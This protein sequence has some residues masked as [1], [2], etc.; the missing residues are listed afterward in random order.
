MWMD[1]LGLLDGVAA[2]LAVF[3]PAV[4]EAPVEELAA[5]LAPASTGGFG[6][7]RARISD[8]GYR[9]A[10]KTALS[11]WRAGKP[12]PA[13]LHA[14]VAAAAGQAAAPRKGAGGGGPP[15]LL[16]DTQTLYK[17]PE[18]ARLRTA[19]GG[20]GLGPLIEEINH[21]HLSTDLALASAEH[22]WLS[23]VLD[24]VSVAD[25]RVGAFDGQAHLRTVAQFGVADR[26][27]I[28]TTAVRVRRA[29]AENATR[30]RGPPPGKTGVYRPPAP[31]Q[32][33]PPAGPPAVPG[34]A[35]CPRRAP[36]MLG[37]VAAAGLPAAAGRA[38]LRRRH[39]RR[40]V[41]GHPGGRGRSAD[42]R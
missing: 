37:D 35:P 4:F 29:V 22:V 33:R 30:P 15:P 7:L 20:A 14:A 13:A 36:A 5:A 25:P 38:M 11:L 31:P 9:R 17:L 34:R 32:A 42:A 26:A 39:L 10:R 19:L 6:R 18:L 2:S 41:P 16:A 40:G 28:D 1:A 24:T 21:R 3:D 8:G 12:K 27:H 23:S